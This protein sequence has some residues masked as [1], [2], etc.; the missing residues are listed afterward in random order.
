MNEIVDILTKK[1]YI[2]KMVVILAGYDQD[3]PRLLRVNFGLSSSRFPEEI[4]F[5][6]MSPAHV[7]RSFA[8]KRISTNILQDRSTTSYVI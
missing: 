7:W 4:M 6:C 3:M 8:G 5:K 2:G 1:R